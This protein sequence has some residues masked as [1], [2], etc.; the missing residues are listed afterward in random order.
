MHFGMPVSVQI[1]I[2]HFVFSEERALVWSWPTGWS[3]NFGQV[4]LAVESKWAFLIIFVFLKFDLPD[5]TIGDIVGFPT[6]KLVKIHNQSTKT[7]LL[8]KKADKL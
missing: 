4:L 2:E 7:Y 5:F 3:V 8:H 6:M 1:S